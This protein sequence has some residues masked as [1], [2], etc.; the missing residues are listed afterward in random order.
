MERRLHL[1]IGFQQLND[2][3]TRAKRSVSN[4]DFELFDGFAHG[5]SVLRFSIERLSV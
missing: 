1:L 4:H 3:K 2:L 5:S